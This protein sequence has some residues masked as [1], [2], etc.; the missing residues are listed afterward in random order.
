MPIYLGVGGIILV[1]S[2]I[3]YLKIGFTSKH[4]RLEVNPIFLETYF[5]APF[6]MVFFPDDGVNGLKNTKNKNFRER[7]IMHKI[8]RLQKIEKK[9]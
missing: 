5:T 4:H 3:E 2:Y 9:C 8:N 1:F 7:K 6:F